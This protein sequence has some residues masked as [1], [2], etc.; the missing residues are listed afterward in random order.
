MPAS[1]RFLLPVAAL[2][3]I[4]ALILVAVTNGDDE[5]AV[6]DTAQ[7]ATQPADEESGDGDDSGSADEDATEDD[8]MEDDAME[9]DAMEDD[10]MEDEDSGTGEPEPEPEPVDP[11][12]LTPGVARDFGPAPAV[13]DGDWPDEAAG[14]LDQVL[15][16]LITGTNPTGQIRTVVDS[17]DPR[18][19]WPLADL[20]RFVGPGEANQTLTGAVQQLL[21]GAEIDP[22]SPWGSTVDHLIAWDVPVPDQQYLNFK[23]NLYGEIEP[24]W[25]ELFTD[26]TEIDWRHVGWGGVG[27]DDREFG[28]NDPC[29]CIPALD[30][31]AVTDADG[32]DWYPDDALIFGL[33]IN[34]ETRAYPKNIM[35]IHEMVNDTLGGRDI[36]M[37][38][39]TLCGSAQAYFTD[40]LPDDLAAEFGRPV[41]R[42]SGLLIRSN[43]MMFERNSRSFIDT[44]QGDAASGP[45][46]DA[47]VVFT[48]TSVVTT[49][50]GEWK[51][52]N[53]DTTII[54]EDGG[55]G[56]T[57]DLDPLQGRDDN[58]PIFPIGDVDPRLPVQEPVLGVI[59]E[60]G[61][62]IA[63]HVAAAEVVLGNGERIEV[64]GIELRPAAGGVRAF[65]NG[66]DAGGHQAFWFAWSQFQP[67]TAVWPL[68]FR[69]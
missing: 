36:G 26:G 47:E 27:I 19:A 30:N 67:D 42:T 45:L 62:P 58:G 10:A 6:D 8:A 28:S 4:G 29:S 32:G 68:D 57:Y 39:C 9:D 20:L 69:G 54:A 1:F 7:G 50:W 63:F 33:E 60:S 61:T 37:P 41:F 17:E 16:L 14:A 56:R 5:Q 31:P 23:R 11:D 53:P 48:Q 2:A 35:E 55:I 49:T 44:F 51:A 15:G 24:K 65:R 43:K 34:G 18:F 22:F 12:N 46:A 64:D 13:P 21:P 40:E 38:Y 66:E 52:A 3:L 25:A 59:G